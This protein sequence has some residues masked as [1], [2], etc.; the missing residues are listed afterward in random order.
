MH[1]ITR[2]EF[3]HRAG[4]PGGG[5][6]FSA[7]RSGHLGYFDPNTAKTELIALGPRSSPYG[8]IQGP[9]QVAWLSE[10]GTGHVTVIR[11]AA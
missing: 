5:V 1:P 11:T 8:V 3:L 9:D 7:Q 4:A 2:R 10:S 6:W